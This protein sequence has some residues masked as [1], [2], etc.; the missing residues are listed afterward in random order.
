MGPTNDEPTVRQ[1]YIRVNVCK[2]RQKVPQKGNKDSEVGGASARAGNTP[3]GTEAD[4]EAIVE[5]RKV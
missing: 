1:G 5:Q 3:E 2:K 4:G